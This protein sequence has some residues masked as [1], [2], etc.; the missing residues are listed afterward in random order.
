MVFRI[1]PQ[2]R[3]LLVTVTG[4][5]TA[6]EVPG[7]FRRAM[8]EAASRQIGRI[9]FNCLE[10]QGNFSITDRL[11]FV[12]QF[13]ENADADALGLRQHFAVVG[14]PPVVDGFAA[15]HLRN[16]GFHVQT[17]PTVSEALNWLG[18]SPPSS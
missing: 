5:I 15:M 10:M 16:R 14:R 18:V 11:N 4:E 7:V 1:E 2:E 3:Y 6:G 8:A 13:T 12:A 17:F 9:L